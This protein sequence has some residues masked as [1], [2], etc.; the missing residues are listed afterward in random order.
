MDREQIKKDL[1]KWDKRYMDLHCH[2]TFSDGSLSPRE[3]IDL[4]KN[5]GIEFFAIADHDTMDGIREAEAYAKL[6][7][8][9]FVSAVELSSSYKG[10]QLHILGYGIDFDN[11]K[12]KE[13]CRKMQ[14]DRHYKNQQIF[15]V[16]DSDFKIDIRKALEKKNKNYIGKPDI[17][18]ILVERGYFQ[19]LH[20]AFENYF[21]K[22]KIEDIKR[23]TIDARDA[24]S[25]IDE[26]G[27]IGVLAHP[28]LVKGIG[29]RGSEEFYAKLEELLIELKA[30]GLVGMES[31]YSKNTDKEIQSLSR[32]AKKLDLV[33]TKGSDFHG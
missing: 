21:R 33:E 19:S 18:R 11:D 30:L 7:Q 24:L 28:I 5:E 26:A 17:G 12:L 27:G 13:L 1:S 14:E 31:H 16:V 9:T 3:V 10:I 6:R 4:K 25:L 20:Q 23:I 8:M 32:I 15:D 2:T 29:L 22:D